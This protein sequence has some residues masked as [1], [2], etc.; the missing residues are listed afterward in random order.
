MPHY[1][2]EYEANGRDV[3]IQQVRGPDSRMGASE[4]GAWI[5]GKAVYLSVIE[6]NPK[7]VPEAFRP[8]DLMDVSEVEKVVSWLVSEDRL[9]CKKCSDTFPFENNV[10]TG[11]AG[12]KCGKCANRDATCTDGDSHDWKCTNPHQKHNARVATKYSCQKCPATKSTT[13]TG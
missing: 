6:E 10:S 5:D 4:P 11:F 3:T 7:I 1:K 13:P 8:S 2:A 12:V 9:V